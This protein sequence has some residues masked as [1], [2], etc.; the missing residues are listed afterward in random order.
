MAITTMLKSTFPLSLLILFACSKNE[1][2]AAPSN[3]FLFTTIGMVETP[4]QPKP[5]LAIWDKY[6]LQEP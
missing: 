6:F 3:I 5:A 1:E 4:F 2:P